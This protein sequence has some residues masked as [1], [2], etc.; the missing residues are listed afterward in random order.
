MRYIR[1]TVLKEFGLDAQKKLTKASVL[2]VGIGGLGI[3]VLQYLNAMG[4]GTLGLVEADTVDITNLQR[5][6]L[7]TENEVGQSKIAI[8]ISKLKAQNSNTIFKQYNTYLTKDNALNICQDFDVIVDASDNF[9]TR[10]LI[11]DVS[12]L[13]KKPFVSGAIQGFEGQLSVFNYNN[14]PTY[15][16]LFPNMPTANEIPNCNENGV[17]GVIPGIIGN[18]QALETVKVITGIGEVLSGTLLLFNGLNQ[19]YQKV[20]F[21]TIPNNLLVT[22]LLN[23]YGNESC[24][25][26]FSVSVLDLKE[27]MDKNIKIQILDVRTNEEYNEY[28]IIN[29]THIPLLELEKNYSKIE[30][31]LPVYVICQSGKRSKI[32]QDKLIKKNIN[33]INIEGG[34][35]AYRNLILIE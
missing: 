26:I 22:K 1:Q 35:N 27:I 33:V 28:H 4:V 31:S 24:N 16:C 23:S 14:G 2:V 32:A 5:Q 6:V 34:I 29:S 21:S 12:V 17:L 11:N 3:P 15:R 18:L 19:N 13:L 25:S 20:K 30:K 7:Y 8:A 9:S 10:Y